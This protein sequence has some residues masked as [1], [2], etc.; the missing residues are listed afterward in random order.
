MCMSV[1]N[2]TQLK[3]AEKNLFRHLNDFHYTRQYERNEQIRLH[4]CLKYITLQHE[5][6][7]SYSYGNEVPFRRNNNQL[8]AQGRR[9]MSSF[10]L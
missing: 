7:C 8:I 9:E 3:C 6:S 5:I 4:G 10:V 1:I 2:I